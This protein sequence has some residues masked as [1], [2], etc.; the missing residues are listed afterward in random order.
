MKTYTL[1]DSIAMTMSHKDLRS[2][3]LDIYPNK[4]LPNKNV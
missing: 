3:M 1:I 2:F 4:E